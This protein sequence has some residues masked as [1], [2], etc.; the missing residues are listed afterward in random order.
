MA[1]YWSSQAASDNN[2]R[3]D[4]LISKLKDIQAAIKADDAQ[5]VSDLVFDAY[6]HQ[7]ERALKP[8]RDYCRR[9]KLS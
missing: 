1:N 2:K 4:A 5:G 9:L 8:L 7:E 3:I 6:K